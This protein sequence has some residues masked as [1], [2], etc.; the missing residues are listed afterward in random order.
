MIATRSSM[1]H[2]LHHLFRRLRYGQPIVV[3]SGLP[4]SGTSMAMKMLEAGGLC[5]VT[6]G[7]RGADE[8][9]PKGYYEYERV[10]NLELDHDRRWLRE[11]RGKAVKIVSFLIKTLPPN[12]N[13]KLLFMQRDLN[14]ILASQAKMLARRGETSEVSDKQMTELFQQDLANARFFLR[15]RQFETLEVQ[16]KETLNHPREQAQRMAAFLGRRLD[17]EAM[18]RVVDATLYRNRA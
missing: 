7:V 17:I 6:D 1:A 14:E 9:N 16:Y 2:T 3:V 15:R 10:K 4:R 5:V 8:D 11:V 12:N 18:V 13:Y